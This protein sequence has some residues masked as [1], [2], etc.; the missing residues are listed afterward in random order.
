MNAARIPRRVPIAAI[1]LMLA[2]LPRCISPGWWVLYTLVLG[3][4]AFVGGS[5]IEGA[6]ASR[7]RQREER[8][9]GQRHSNRRRAGAV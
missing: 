5:I 6:I 2:L 1:G 3:L 8:R 4:C 7:R 9:I